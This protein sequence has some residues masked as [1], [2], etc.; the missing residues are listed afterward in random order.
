MEANFSL[1][2]GLAVQLYEATLISG[3]TPFDAFLENAGNLTTQQANGH[4]LFQAVGC[5]GCHLLPTFTTGADVA[6]INAGALAGFPPVFMPP[7]GAIELMNTADRLV[8][9]Y[10]SAWNNIGVTLDIIQIK[11]NIIL[12]DEFLQQNLDCR[13]QTQFFH[14]LG[15]QIHDKAPDIVDQGVH[16]GQK[17]NDLLMQAIL[18]GW[19]VVQDT[20]EL[21]F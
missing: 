20:P 15:A 3:E 8:A 17:L 11:G 18:A 2:F 19:Q 14:D 5:A 21:E 7:A 4:V 16:R 1:F 10:D 9:F 12:L 13:S 6:A